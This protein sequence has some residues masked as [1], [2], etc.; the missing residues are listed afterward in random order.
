MSRPAEL[1]AQHE[2][3]RALPTQERVFL[4]KRMYSRTFQRGET[5]IRQGEPIEVIIFIASGLVSVVQTDMTGVGTELA[6]LGDGAL[7]GELS[8]LTGNVPNATVTALIEC[9][10][11]ALNRAD[12]EAV[13]HR[14]IPLAMSV[15]RMLSSKLAY[16]NQRL[17]P[18]RN[19]QWSVIL[20]ENGA[21]YPLAVPIAE[22]VAHYSCDPVVVIDAY[23]SALSPF[24]RAGYPAIPIS[25]VVQNGDAVPYHPSVK[26]VIVVHATAQERADSSQI[27]TAATYLRTIFR[28]VLF[29][30]PP[31]QPHLLADILPLSDQIMVHFHRT[32]LGKAGLL[33]KMPELLRH[34]EHG[35]V[36][37]SAW[38]TTPKLGD[39]RRLEENL[40]WRVAAMVS[41]DAPQ[42]GIDRAA[43]TI[44]K[45]RVGLAWGGG[46]ARGWA[47]A[48]IANALES[49]GVPMDLFAGTSAGALGAAVYGLS[50]NYQEA[51][52][53]MRQILPYLERTTRLMPP[54]TISS[55]SLLRQGWWNDLIKTFVGDLTFD[56][57]LLPFAAVAL[58]LH[59]GM[60]KV[61]DRGLLWQAIRASSAIPVLAPP[62]MIEGRAY[63]D[64]GVVNAVPLDVVASMGADIL[65]GID[66][67]G[68]ERA[69]EEW[70]KDSTPNMLGTLTRTINVAYNISA[71]RTLP[72]AH[73]LIRPSLRAA[74]VYDVR[75]MDE[76]IAEGERATYAALPEL[77]KVL[78]WLE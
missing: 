30:L 56:D 35:T 40:G 10:V 25:H 28:H 36:V 33:L 13:L 26:E 55:H 67:T 43:R 53:R 29:A 2:M 70:S 63:A 16:A 22:R 1:L 6:Q 42:V 37:V 50:L 23:P 14:S 19:G 74:A 41:S 7:V 71:S 62:M 66:L 48:G 24:R 15:N 39:L 17:T 72:L 46:T 12:F 18:R 78:K 54:I 68:S 31:S 8:M 52:A 61:F 65:I 58:D 27:L 44:A 51:G 57:L 38:H 5:I 45:M 11:W 34:H 64:G 77:K 59:T 76:F 4:A 21:D 32:R 69:A 3:F 49:I 9:E 75:V 73:I 47:L 60:P 20:D